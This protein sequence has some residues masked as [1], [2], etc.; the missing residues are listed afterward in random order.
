MLKLPRR[1][2]LRV[3]TK[4]FAFGLFFLVGLGAIGT[5]YFFQDQ[6]VDGYRRHATDA[7]TN[8]EFAEVLRSGIMRLQLTE[9]EFLYT[10]DE[11]YA[12]FHKE[13]A[14]TANSAVSQLLDRLSTEDTAGLTSVLT[15]VK[16]GLGDHNTVFQKMV[17]IKKKLGFYPK[18]GLNGVILKASADLES[19]L[20]AAG[21]SELTAAFETLK[22]LEKDYRLNHQPTIYAAFGEQAV[23]MTQSLAKSTIDASAMKSIHDASDAYTEGVAAWVQGDQSFLSLYQQLAKNY[24]DLEPQLNN[25][26]S[27]IKAQD[28]EAT[29]NENSVR[30]KERVQLAIAFGVIVLVTIL[31]AWIVGRGIAHPIARITQAMKAVAAGEFASAIPYAADTSEIGDMARALAVFASGLAETE[32]LRIRQAEAEKNAA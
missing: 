6:T 7:R 31:L 13:A 2:N 11:R 29:S 15:S 12:S 8:A 10:N 25:L 24:S 9:F 5:I 14:L 22:A 17:D 30:E 27:T 23:A 19:A 28:S 26:V 18:S 20:K 3:A 1:R 21:D 4:I 16:T 32:C